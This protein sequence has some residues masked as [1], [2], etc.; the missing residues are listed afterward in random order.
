ML[1]DTITA[2]FADVEDFVFFQVGQAIDVKPTF[3]VIKTERVE[4]E[5]FFIFAT[6]LNPPIQ[7]T[8]GGIFRRPVGGN[9]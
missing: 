9:G 8:A 2:A 5:N 3:A 4:S 7:F 6:I 1:E